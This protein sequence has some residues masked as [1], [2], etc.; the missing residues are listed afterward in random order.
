MYN[1]Y[2]E[3]SEGVFCR[4]CQN[5]F[6]EFVG[7]KKI[8]KCLVY[9]ATSDKSTDIHPMSTACGFFN[10]PFDEL[11]DMPMIGLIGLRPHARKQIMDRLKRQITWSEYKLKKPC[12]EQDREY[13]EKKKADSE[14]KLSELMTLENIESKGD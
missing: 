2:G 6:K 13:Y 14:A 9:G 11:T 7:G 3:H 8:F 12:A 10:M 1:K 4:Q 5:C